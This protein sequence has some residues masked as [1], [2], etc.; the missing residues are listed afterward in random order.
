MC[1]L[2]EA[3]EACRHGQEQIAQ[4]APVRPILA[5]ITESSLF[6]QL[7]LVQSVQ[8]VHTVNMSLTKTAAALLALARILATEPDPGRAHSVDT[9]NVNTTTVTE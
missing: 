2:R 6:S 4:W 1:T 8:S 3:C 9:T 7:G 5:T